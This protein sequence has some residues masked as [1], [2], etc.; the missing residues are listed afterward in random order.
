MHDLVTRIGEQLS[1]IRGEQRFYRRRMARHL[2]TNESMHRRTKVYWVVEALVLV[3]ITATQCGLCC[4]SLRC[5]VRHVPYQ[6]HCLTRR[7]RCRQDL[8]K[9]LVTLQLH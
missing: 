1:L 3:M 5:F 2:R 6:R 9:H 4:L 7:A 8:L